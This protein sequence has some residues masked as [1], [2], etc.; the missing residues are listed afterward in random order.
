MKKSTLWILFVISAA[1]LL[2][3]GMR[4]MN[5]SQ[6][7]TTPVKSQLPT[8]NTIELSASDIVR[9]QAMDMVLGLQVSG[10]LKASQSAMVKARVVGELL[11]LTVRE[12]DLVKAGQ[13][14]A[15]FY[16]TEY[17]ARERQAKQQ[18]DAAGAGHRSHGF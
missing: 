3:G 17:Q 10:T 2:A 6:S 7:N 5:P 9:V 16:P 14:I 15:R 12:G 8:A 18:A 13:V 4:W 11:D 1:A